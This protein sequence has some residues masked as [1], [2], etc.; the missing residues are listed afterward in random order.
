MLPKPDTNL[1]VLER[2]AVAG[3]VD[4]PAADFS[5]LQSEFTAFSTWMNSWFSSTE[6]M[7][8]LNQE[9][10]NHNGFVNAW[11]ESAL[12]GSAA[13]A[14]PPAVPV[15]RRTDSG[16]V[17]ISQ[18]QLNLL[19]S[20]TTTFISWMGASTNSSMANT[21]AIKSQIKTEFQAYQG[22]VTAWLAA[23]T[24][25]GASASAAPSSPTPSAPASTP[26][27]GPESPSSAV[28]VVSPTPSPA[29]TPS[30]SSSSVAA[31]GSGAA[32]PAATPA[33]SPAS[34]G[35]F[36]AKAKDNVAV[37]YGQSPATSQVTLA[38]L[39]SDDS[40]NIVIL[41]FL[42]EFFSAGGLPTMDFGPACG[43]QS[44]QMEAKGATGMLECGQMATDI[45]TCQSSGKKVLLSLG[46]AT[47]QTA[48][49]GDDQAKTFASTL[50]NLFGAG[51]GLDAALR[52][53]GKTTID[54]FDVDNEDKDQTG[55]VA[56]VQALRTQFATDKS[57]QYYISA[58][59]QCP[60]PDASIPVG[61]MQLMDFVWVQF[62]NNGVCDIGQS[63]FVD[64]FTAWSKNIAGG[65]QLY[66]GAPACTACAGTGYLA[67]EA[68]TSAIKS[69]TAANVP[70]MGGVML[71]D[72]SEG[73][74]NTAGGQNYNQVV[75]AAL[76]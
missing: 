23:A 11:L 57:K 41:A 43:G 29:S 72:G 18:A 26:V 4:M 58:A 13:P 51:T 35:S 1:V 42:S 6:S 5:M 52:P 46:G 56:F 54:G 66:I 63:G 48:F 64:S 40:I 36:N 31:V 45:A 15:S 30:S 69:A 61:A 39:C 7:Q 17:E 22:W 62:Y 55:Y 47:A 19:Q 16:S 49:T 74:T 53:F 65:P 24:P 20:E 38:K 3:S 10:Q 68:V 75:K 12:S 59:P 25:N 2:R 44:S 32:A 33:S 8:Q 9:L 27:T 67:P 76:G 50:W 37:Y 28:T 60:L 21:D 70:N 71:W 34:S 14:L 73:M